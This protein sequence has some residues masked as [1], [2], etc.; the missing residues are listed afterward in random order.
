MFAEVRR[1]QELREDF[2]S[3]LDQRVARS[4]QVQRHPMIANTHFASASS[5]CMQLFRDGRF[6]GCIALA[7]AVAEA[8]ARFLCQRKR[9][10]PAKNYEQNIRRLFEREFI[11]DGLRQWFDQIWERRDDYHHLNPG[12]MTDREELEKLALEKVNLLNEIEKEIF[13][14]RIA[15]DGSAI[16]EHPEYWDWDASGDGFIDVYLRFEP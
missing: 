5:E 6:Y 3:T 11:S 16:L 7:Q 4:L 2:E 9:W 8:L 15:K 12:V 1:Q 13:A 14:F 10:R